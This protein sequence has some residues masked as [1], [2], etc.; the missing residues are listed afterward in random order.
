MGT[1]KEVPTVSDPQQ[2]AFELKPCP[3]CGGEA[4]LQLWANWS[5][6]Q[7]VRCIACEVE[8]GLAD[9]AQ[10]AAAAWNRRVKGTDDG[11]K[12]DC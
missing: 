3:F 11:I 9:D 7:I 8:T 4:K 6:A 5:D 2:P 10:T 1:S 12:D